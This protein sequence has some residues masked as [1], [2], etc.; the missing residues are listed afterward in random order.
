MH[1]ISSHAFLVQKAISNYSA[2]GGIVTSEQ[3]SANTEPFSTDWLEGTLS[4]VNPS[5]R[6]SVESSRKWPENELQP[7]FGPSSSAAVLMR[8]SIT[9]IF[10]AI[11][12]TY[13]DD[14]AHG[15]G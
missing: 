9:T 6:N 7:T 15:I 2:P 4:L 12:M 11:I 3:K 13:A 1:I 14:V 8:P 5:D 10:P